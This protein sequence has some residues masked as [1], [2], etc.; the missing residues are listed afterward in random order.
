[1]GLKRG[2]KTFFVANWYSISKQKLNKVWKHNEYDLQMHKKAD[3]E[4]E[5][6]LSMVQADS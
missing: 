3:L 1:M 6:W 4:A 2:N 5:K